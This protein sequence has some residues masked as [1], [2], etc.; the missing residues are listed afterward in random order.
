MY[1]YIT[2]VFESVTIL[3]YISVLMLT[4]KYINQLCHKTIKARVMKR[5]KVKTGKSVDYII[6][7]RYA[8]NKEM[9]NVKVQDDYLSKVGS[10]VSLYTDKNGVLHQRC[11]L[12]LYLVEVGTL[13][14]I[15][16]SILYLIGLML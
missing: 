4:I 13:A 14:F 12:R 16:T 15:G 3:C 9:Y 1:K 11:S 5:K 2:T 7:C 10:V 6:Y 8:K